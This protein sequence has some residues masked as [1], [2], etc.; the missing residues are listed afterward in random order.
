M[1]RKKDKDLE[2]LYK[3]YAISE[4][5][6]KLGK[7]IQRNHTVIGVDI[8]KVNT[9]ICVLKTTDKLL[10]VVYFDKILVKTKGKLVH[11][12]LDEFIREFKLFKL[13]LFRRERYFNYMLI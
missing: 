5:E 9:G 4:L 10:N 12:C 1:A 3:Q 7:V 2:H 11:P 8:A 13:R 6:D